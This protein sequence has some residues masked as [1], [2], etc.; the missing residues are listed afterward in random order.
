MPRTTDRDVQAVGAIQTMLAPGERLVWH[1]RPEMSRPLAA[2]Q[3]STATVATILGAVLLLLAFLHPDDAGRLRYAL[4]AP[5]LVAVATAGILAALGSSWVSSVLRDNA[6]AVTDR[7]AIVV[8]CG[9]SGPRITE[10][11]PAHIAYVHVYPIAEG[12]ADVIFRE[13]PNLGGMPDP[14]RRQGRELNPIGFKRIRDAEAAAAALWA[15]REGG[16]LA[17]RTSAW[18]PSSDGNS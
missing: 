7:R 4:L 14:K 13:G 1:G 16:T 5:A 6:Y 3:R 10:F 9:R 2:A 8:R 17:S 12:V 15:L 11:G 18:E